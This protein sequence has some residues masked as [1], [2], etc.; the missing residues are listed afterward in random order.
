MFKTKLQI[1]QPKN[2]NFR[3]TVLSHGWYSLP[4][5]A[6]DKENWILE[7]V[8]ALAGA[9]PFLAQIY[10][11][12]NK[13]EIAIEESLSPENAER[14]KRLVRHVL[15]LD[16]NFTGFYDLV[17]G[18]P[19][20]AWIAASGAGRL[21]RSPTV[22]EDLV[23][24]IC[25]TNCSWAL[26]QKI[27]V[28]LV[29]KLGQPTGSKTRKNFPTAEAMSSQTIDFYKTEIRAGYR[30]DYLL[31]LAERVASGELVVEDWLKSD[32]STA[33]LKK[34]IKQVKG[35]GDYAAENLLKLI[36][37]YDGLAL[38]SWLR[39]GFAKKHNRGETAPDKQ[40]SEHYERF[41]RWRG[42][43]LWCEMTKD[44]L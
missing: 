9:Q 19:D 12:E 43:A 26:T 5:F 4:P 18:E 7:R 1:V 20:F 22:Y 42:L 21:L 25:T 34:Q 27:I 28:N 31:E 15:Q 44:W 30:S 14:L 40:I 8:F 2:F 39:A 6:L 38:D 3:R 32:L 36:N 24:S 29:E 16:E 10:E 11:T 35:V 17:K 13:I 41:G 23:K 33:E 37:R